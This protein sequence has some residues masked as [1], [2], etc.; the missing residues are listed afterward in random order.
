MKKKVW[1]IENIFI[2]NMVI[3]M[4]IYYEKNAVFDECGLE[5]DKTKTTFLG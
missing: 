4:R 1:G 2:T 5:L 3:C